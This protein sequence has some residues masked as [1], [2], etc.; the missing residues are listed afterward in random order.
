MPA[1]SLPWKTPFF[2]LPMYSWQPTSEHGPSW[3]AGQSARA[4]SSGTVSS[5]E[6]H[7][8]LP[9]PHIW[10]CTPQLSY[11]ILDFEVGNKQWL[12]SPRR[13][14][15]AA[16]NWAVCQRTL[17]C[18]DLPEVFSG[19]HRQISW[20]DAATDSHRDGSA[21]LWTC[22]T[23][24]SNGE[25]LQDTLARQVSITSN[26]PNSVLAVTIFA[27][28]FKH[29]AIFATSSSNSSG[30]VTEFMKMMLAS[31]K[32]TF[33]KLPRTNVG[34]GLKAWKGMYK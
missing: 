27:E 11:A 16:D 8:I 12:E 19:S 20:D 29:S 26:G 4:T 9:S 18:R 7:V 33:A 21:A 31:L 24:Y 34:N 30:K 3:A 10:S 22:C 23:K 1:A 14:S 17:R 32:S 25:S 15:R 2:K 6:G 28:G 13:I 5:P